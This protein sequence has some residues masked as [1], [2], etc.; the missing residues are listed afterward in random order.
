MLNTLRSTE[1][2]TYYTNRV[3]VIINDKSNTDLNSI[4]SLIRTTFVVIV[5]VSGAIFFTNDT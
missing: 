1:V 5:M 3:V 2:D 4:L